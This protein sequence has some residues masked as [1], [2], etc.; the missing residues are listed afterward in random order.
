MVNLLWID[1]QFAAQKNLARQ[2]Q[3]NRNKI[4]EV[5]DTMQRRIVMHGTD[6]DAAERARLE[7]L[8]QQRAKA[9]D[10]LQELRQ[11]LIAPD[12]MAGLLE[13]ILKRHGGL[14]LV[15]LRT[16]PSVS[17]SE[18]AS[19]AVPAQP[20]GAPAA[21]SPLAAISAGAAQAGLSVSPTNAPTAAATPAA[22]A[23]GIFKHGVEI[24]LQGNYADVL[25]YMTELES[26][27]WQV[28]WGKAEYAVETYPK[29]TVTLTLYTLSLDKKWLHL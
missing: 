19:R 26:M 21:P 27:P 5:Q 18:P 8:R 25:Q 29:A 28:F 22:E 10:E 23:G 16:L 3:E 9:Q 7:T 14:R 11:G 4:Q 12:K 17:L 2:M 6:P 13:D 24:T 1:P 15:A 20:Q